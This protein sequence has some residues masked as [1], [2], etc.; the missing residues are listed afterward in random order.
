MPPPNG[1]PLHRAQPHRRQIVRENARRSRA[2]SRSRRQ[3]LIVRGAHKD[4]LG[5]PGFEAVSSAGGTAYQVAFENGFA[6]WTLQLQKII[7]MKTRDNKWFSQRHV[8]GSDEW[9]SDKERNRSLLGIAAD[10][11][12][13][14]G[15]IAKWMFEEPRKREPLGGV[16]WHCVFDG[17]KIFYQDFG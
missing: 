15:G 14:H 12:V 16:M 1:R 6:L 11:E 4:A 13:P 3:S 17:S 5:K 8:M 9:T 7:V 2:S 10:G